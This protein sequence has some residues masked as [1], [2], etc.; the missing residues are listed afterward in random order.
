MAS[1]DMI[2]RLVPAF[3]MLLE[4]K[5]LILLFGFLISTGFV[6][7]WREFFPCWDTSS[8]LLGYATGKSVG[9]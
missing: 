3:L 2:R 8:D 7:V 5:S 6:I 4:L 1:V 9:T